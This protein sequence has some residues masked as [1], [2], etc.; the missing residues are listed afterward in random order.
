MAWW[1]CNAGA[2]SSSS[3]RSRESS[4]PVSIPAFTA[5]IIFLSYT[6]FFQVHPALALR[7]VPAA[8]APRGV[9]SCSSSDSGSYNEFLEQP[10]FSGGD[11][12]GLYS[13]KDTGRRH[14]ISVSFES[15]HEVYHAA[16]KVSLVPFNNELRFFFGVCVRTSF[17]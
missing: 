13:L 15:S 4:A 6:G 5:V 3:H 16:A 2:T 9:A 8:A 1:W 11:D 7:S 10:N 12:V 17:H 14:L